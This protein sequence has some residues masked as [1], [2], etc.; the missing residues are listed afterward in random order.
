MESSRNMILNKYSSFVIL[1]VLKKDSTPT[2]VLKEV[3][4]KLFE[5]D[6]FILIVKNKHGNNIIDKVSSYF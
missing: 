1:Q 4:S 5:K 2:K 3:V 6:N